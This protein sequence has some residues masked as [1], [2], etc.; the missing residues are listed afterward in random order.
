MSWAAWYILLTPLVMLSVLMVW[1][2]YTD[3]KIE[4]QYKERQDDE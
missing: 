3:W 4:Q 1:A 2:K